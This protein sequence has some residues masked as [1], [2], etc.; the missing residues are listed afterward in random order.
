MNR[1][2]LYWKNKKIIITLVVLTIFGYGIVFLLNNSFLTIKGLGSE[3]KNI[4]VSSD[5]LGYEFK[6]KDGSLRKF[7]PKGTYRVEVTTDQTLSVYKVSIGSF[8]FNEIQVEAVQQKNSEY[9]GESNL[10]CSK[11]EDGVPFFFYC[12][13]STLGIIESPSIKT[14]SKPGVEPEMGEESISDSS[15]TIAIIGGFLRARTLNETLQIEVVNNRIETVKKFSFSGFKSKVND[16]SVFYNKNGEIVALDPAGSRLL[17][18][19]ENQDAKTLDISKYKLNDSRL[20]LEVFANN[21]EAYIVSHVSSEGVEDHSQINQDDGGEKERSK[22]PERPKI[23]VASISSGSILNEYNLPEDYSAIKT[24]FSNEGSLVFAPA[25]GNS[26][27]LYFKK[28]QGIKNIEALV[29]KPQDVCWKNNDEFYYT[30]GSSRSIYVYSL[31]RSVSFL[32]YNNT[33]SNISRVNCFADKIY[34]SIESDKDGLDI[35]YFFYLSDR[36]AP[37]KRLESLLPLTLTVG[38]S[39]VSAKQ[40]SSDEI[41]LSNIKIPSFPS[42][43]TSDSVDLMKRELSENGYNVDEIKIKVE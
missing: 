41:V 22:K 1:G 25:T 17:V 42:A 34:F 38:N 6:L 24:S 21:D 11:N 36:V 39:L 37:N 14:V 35:G 43:S 27:V 23:I 19:K 2:A 4:V 40:K 32:A 9:L 5:V 29:D 10:P 7:L 33:T 3:E 28:N 26:P 8:W 15:A 13:P 31:S 18:F 16:K 12:N 20:N 30:D